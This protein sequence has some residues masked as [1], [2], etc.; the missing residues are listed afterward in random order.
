MIVT[1]IGASFHLDWKTL[2][3]PCN[4]TFQP[5]VAAV[6]S[7]SL[8]YIMNPGKGERLV[9]LG[10]TMNINLQND[11][12]SCMVISIKSV[13]FLF[14][15]VN[16]EGLKA[17]MTDVAKYCSRQTAPAECHPLPGAACCAQF[18]GQFDLQTMF[19]F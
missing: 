11:Y 18:S 8:F 13:G 19:N 12:N 3:L 2:E 14:V 17:V 5:R 16:A 10:K 7:P 6:I 9:N 1:H 15:L 4:E